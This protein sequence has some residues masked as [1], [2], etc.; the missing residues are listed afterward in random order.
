KEFGESSPAA[1]ATMGFNHTWIFLN[2][3]LPRAIQKYGGVTP[4]AIRQAALETDIPEGG[5]P[6]GYGVKFAPPGHEMAG[7]NLRAYPVL[8]QWINGKVEIVWPPALKTAEP[9]LPLP[10][11]S[12]YGG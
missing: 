3:V 1:H 11:D 6:G 5:T 7:Q 2:D 10:P 9:I 8:M 4:D 12:P